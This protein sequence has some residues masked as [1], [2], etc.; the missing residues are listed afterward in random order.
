MAWLSK[1]SS[2]Y[3]V[4]EH[5]NSSWLTNV[6]PSLESVKPIGS[7]LILLAVSIGASLTSVQVDAPLLSLKWTW[8]SWVYDVNSVL[9]VFQLLPMDGSP[10]SSETPL[11]ARY[12]WNRGAPGAPWGG[13]VG[14]HPGCPRFPWGWGGGAKQRGGG[15]AG[16][17]GPAGPAGKGP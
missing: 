14:G 8:Y 7:R 5:G 3:D 1:S 6:R 4:P 16:V 17:A 2:L 10:A 12:C 13:G 9:P 11:G 15:G